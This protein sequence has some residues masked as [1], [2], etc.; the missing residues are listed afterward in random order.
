MQ[1]SL[2]ILDTMDPPN[3][4][5]QTSS[6]SVVFVGVSFFTVVQD[7][8]T[9]PTLK[10]NPTKVVC[11]LQK[12]KL[13]CLVVLQCHAVVARIFQEGFSFYFLCFLMQQKIDDASNSS[14]FNRK[15]K[16]KQIITFV[17]SRLLV[18]CHRWNVTIMNNVTEKLFLKQ[19]FS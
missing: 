10:Y 12:G 5:A 3:G 19:A 2:P 9:I 15:K 14:S 11:T 7:L 17:R 1:R 13:H 4:K 16:K 8:L 6:G 18:D